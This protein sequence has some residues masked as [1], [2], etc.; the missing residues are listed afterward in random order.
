MRAKNLTEK[1]LKA[2]AGTAKAD[3]GAI[4]VSCP[5]CCRSL[6]PWEMRPGE[7]AVLS[8]TLGHRF[9]VSYSPEEKLFMV[10]E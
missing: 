2:K 10:E 3:G 1:I 7:S 6:Y 5:R 4:E 8:D 9:K